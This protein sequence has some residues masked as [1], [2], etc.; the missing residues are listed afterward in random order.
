MRAV[1][2]KAAEHYSLDQLERAIRVAWLTGAAKLMEG[3]Y[4]NLGALLESRTGRRF[5]RR[6][7]WVF[8][9]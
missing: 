8:S 2:L 1:R 5:R 4:K 3:R 9:K 7:N 6:C